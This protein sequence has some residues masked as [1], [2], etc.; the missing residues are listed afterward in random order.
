M[1][2]TAL[3][4]GATGLIGGQ[5]LELLLADPHYQHVVVLARKP[6]PSHPKL[7]VIQTDFSELQE[8]SV[9]P[10]QD[11]FC[12][13]GTTI[14][15][16]GSKEAFRKVDLEYP[17]AVGAWALRQGAV[18]YLL[19]SALGADAR[20]RIFYNRV[21]GEVE[22]K[23]QQLGY[24]S[25]HIFRPSLLMRPRQESRPG[26]EAAKQFNRWFGFLIPAAY[27]GIESIKVARAMQQWA[28]KSITG[29]HVH[30]SKELQ[31]F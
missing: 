17:L 30:E 29:I 22:Q 14:K 8:K 23:I 28:H 1:S 20:S 16:A 7:T 9:P 10:I 6:L 13:L 3:V 11:V 21:K 2:K 5:L 25:V 26:E 27:R 31:S 18:Q 15:V 24:S 19:V 12:C 4:V